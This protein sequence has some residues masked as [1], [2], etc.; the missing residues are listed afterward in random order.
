MRPSQIYGTGKNGN[1][2]KIAKS[3][4]SKIKE[5]CEEIINV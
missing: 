5:F 4:Y 2:V 3:I 1:T